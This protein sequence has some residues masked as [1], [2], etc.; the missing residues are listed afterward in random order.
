MKM[1]VE[2]R[3]HADDSCRWALLREHSD[4]N[5]IRVVDPIKLGV[6]SCINA[7]FSERSYTLLA[8]FEVGDQL[9]VDLL[10]TMN[11]CDW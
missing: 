6:W 11:V 3:V 7:L 8:R 9:V 4:Q 10:V 1:W 5:E 2:A